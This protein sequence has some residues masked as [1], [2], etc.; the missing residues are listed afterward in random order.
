[1]LVAAI[2]LPWVLWA[3]V[4][5]FG[6]DVG[7]P[8]VAVI[9][10]TPY[11]AATALVPLAIALAAREWVVAALAALALTALVLAVAPRALG[12]GDA[13]AADGRRLVVMSANL[14]FGAA[15][16]ASLLAL[17]R[18][19]DVDLLS[20][21]EL[22]PEAVD[23][24]DAAGARALLPGRALAPR[25]G[26]AG[27]GL[28]ARRPLR[29]LVE[30]IPEGRA[31]LRA[32]LELPG[33]DALR[34]VAVHPFPPVTRSSEHDWHEVLR[35]LP[36]ARERGYRHVLLGDFNAT[37]DHRE[38]RRVL[39]RGYV[40]GADARGQGLRPTFPVGRKKYPPLTLDHVLVERSIAVRALSV[41]RL[42]GSDHRAVVAEIV[43]P[44]G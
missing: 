26:A 2:T 14:R 10:F 18:E 32:A 6:L 28:M 19:H 39:D 15:D 16:A 21:Q 9:A 40:D 41:H 43:L 30:P 33:G 22:T 11:A 36:D 17:V 5:T 23:A 37:L 25:S 44:A 8:L 20:L 4:R 38:L 29:L 34:V 24:L 12:G 35:A 1:V 42:S 27:T 13:P 7:Y 3:L 31:Q